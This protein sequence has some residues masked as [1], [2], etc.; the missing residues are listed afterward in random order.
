MTWCL[1]DGAAQIK[2]PLPQLCPTCLVLIDG[3]MVTALIRRDR[4]RSG[5]TPRWE[6]IG[7]EN[8]DIDT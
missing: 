7:L 3:G 5:K 8:H 4:V 6:A 1:M 2:L